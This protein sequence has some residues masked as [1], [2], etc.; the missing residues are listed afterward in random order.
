MARVSSKVPLDRV[1]CQQRGHALSRSRGIC[2]SPTS[3]ISFDN[4]LPAVVASGVDGAGE[5]GRAHL[6]I[7][8]NLPEDEGDGHGVRARRP[9][10]R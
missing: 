9:R 3:G 7:R 1:E 8:A 2:F 10:W 6:A 4:P 5:D